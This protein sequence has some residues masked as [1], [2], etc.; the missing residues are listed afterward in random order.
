MFSSLLFGVSGPLLAMKQNLY[1]PLESFTFFQL[2]FWSAFCRCLVNEN[3][4]IAD[5]K[6]Q[7]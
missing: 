1:I 6:L 2:Y 7:N 4:T 3:K 5:C